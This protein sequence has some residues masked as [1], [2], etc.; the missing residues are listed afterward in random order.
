M[1]TEAPTPTGGE[2]YTLEFDGG[3][4]GNPGP[5][6][7]GIV[8]RFPDGGVMKRRRFLGSKTNNEAE[9]EA[10]ISGLWFAH[11]MGARKLIIMGDS[12]LVIEQVQGHYAVKASNLKPLCDMAQRRLAA[13]F[14]AYVMSHIPR[15]Q[16]GE[17]DA[18]VNKSL[19]RVMR[20]SGGQGGS[21][22]MHPVG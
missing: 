2:W 21:K 6:S 19:N 22:S 5:A 7:I 14:E 16:N 11:K 4:R 8:L 20:L 17:A 15:E 1:A 12:K 13:W 9:Y 10:L 3:S 18:L